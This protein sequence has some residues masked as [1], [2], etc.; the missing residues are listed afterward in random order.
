MG[1]EIDIS[2]EI[3]LSM[4]LFK[5]LCEQKFALR[6][7]GLLLLERSVIMHIKLAQCHKCYK[8]ESTFL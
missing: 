2:F 5:C 3:C 4:C 6:D 7:N 8:L 1:T